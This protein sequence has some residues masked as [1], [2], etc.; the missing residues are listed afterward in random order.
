MNIL[1]INGSPKK[2]GGASSFFS[3]IAELMLFPHRVTVKSLGMSRNYDTLFEHLQSVDVVILSAPLYVD[4]IPSHLIPFLKQ[5]EEYC[6]NNPCKFMLYVISNSGFIEGRQNR[7]HLQQY[8]CWCERAGIVWGGGLG[9]GGGVMLHVIFYMTLLESIA[10]FI[11]CVIINLVSGKPL[12]TSAL[13]T[14]L[15]RG[16]GIWLFLCSGML[17]CELRMV[18]AIKKKRCM[19]NLYTRVMIPSLLFLVVADMYMAVIALLHGKPLFLLYK[20]GKYIQD[21]G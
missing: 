10:E 5:M 6:A 17:F 9:I 8:Q 12:I 4:G 20:K 11:I 3:K 13:L 19:R 16:I 14:G 7:A 1:V 18:L 21:I 2:R 15:M